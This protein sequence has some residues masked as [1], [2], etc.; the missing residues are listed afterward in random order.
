MLL[1]SCKS[2]MLN[3][4]LINAIAIGVIIILNWISDELDGSLDVTKV[5]EIKDEL[6]EIGKD[7]NS[8]TGIDE[9]MTGSLKIIMKTEGVKGEV[10]EDKL[11]IEDEIVESGFINWLKRIFK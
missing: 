7:N 11:D 5:L 4:L 10:E 2:G 8:F 1:R 3:A 9:D 6:V